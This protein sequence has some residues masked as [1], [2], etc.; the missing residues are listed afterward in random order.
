MKVIMFLEGAQ[1]QAYDK[2]ICI[3]DLKRQKIIVT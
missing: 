3:W 1:K 2:W